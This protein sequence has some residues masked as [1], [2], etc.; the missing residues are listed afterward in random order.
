MGTRGTLGVA[1][2]LVVAGTLIATPTDAQAIGGLSTVTVSPA[3][4]KAAA[5]FQVTY[6]I[7]PCQLAAGLTIGFSWNGLTP[8][9]QV[10]G[11][12]ATDAACRAT[13]TT[14]PPLNA[15]HQ[16]PA[17]GSYQVFGYVALP[18]GTPA[19]NTEASTT[20]T[21]DVTPAPTA[22]ASAPSTSAKSVPSA[23]A[24]ADTTAPSASAPT[25]SNQADAAGTAPSAPRKETILRFLGPGAGVLVLAIVAAMTFQLL[26]MVRRRRARAAPG[27]SK[28]KAA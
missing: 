13:L 7:I 23:S 22:T 4:G 17:P 18:T 28:D 8:A 6:A 15:A 14:K 11:T 27:P 21:V 20:Y 26:S 16:P 3:H 2:L 10:L 25:G 5:Q 9:G 19:P 12:A 24:P 1:G